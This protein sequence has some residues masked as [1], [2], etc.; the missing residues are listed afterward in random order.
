MF[1][2]SE[3]EAMQQVFNFNDDEIKT[4]DEIDTWSKI[5]PAPHPEAGSN[6]AEA[7]CQMAIGMLTQKGLWT[8]VGETLSAIKCLPKQAVLATRPLGL[9][10]VKLLNLIN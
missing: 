8:E 4:L 2:A 10:I 1:S 6:A 5:N 7:Y 9:C 3:K